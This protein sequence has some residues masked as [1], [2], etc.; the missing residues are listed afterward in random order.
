M[1]KFVKVCTTVLAMILAMSLMGCTI[2]NTH[3]E[4]DFIEGDT[5]E[6]APIQLTVATHLDSQEQSLM[7]SWI[8]AYKDVNKDVGIRISQTLIGMDDLD[9]MKV[10]KTLPDIVWTTGDA[11]QLYSEKG[12]FRDL[13]DK[14]MFEGTDEFFG[15]MYE[16]LV[17]TTHYNNFENGKW[18]VPR[19][20]NRLTIIYNKTLFE[21]M[22]IDLPQ[23][24]W[25]WEQFMDTCQKLQSDPNK[26]GYKCAKAISWGNWAPI[27][28]TMMKNF[29]ARYVDEE[30]YFALDDEKGEAVYDWSKNFEKTYSTPDLD[31]TSFTSWNPTRKKAGTGMFLKQY[32][33]LGS[34]VRAADANQ[35]EVD[36]VSFP[37]YTAADNGKGYVGAG[38][39]G[40]AITTA[41]T[42]ETKI[43][44]AWE[45]LKF[46]M[47]REGYDAV[48]SVGI[49][50]PALQSMADEGEWTNYS[51][52][53]RKINYKAFVDKHTED[54]DV[55]YAGVVAETAKQKV[56]VDAA[57]K[58][59]T[60]MGDQGFSTAV[61]AFKESY[62]SQVKK[63]L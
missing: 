37:Q 39:S 18:F 61:A 32:A 14:N 26:S 42:D 33:G 63:R 17:R 12:F 36:A 45:F 54:I 48:A 40:Y 4:N 2:K 23:D 34:C 62:E 9:T 25:T 7:N 20:Y 21:L 24:G 35:W 60:N 11:H 50:C 59:W 8:R 46:C 49:L 16:S 51:Q 57:L 55:N 1:K 27:H 30:G 22:G 47:S 58:F 29:G 19:D 3:K 41:C 13:S 44:A 38:C 6:N 15:G 52:G 28:L 53:E 31:G 56:I 43:K 10:A 5:N